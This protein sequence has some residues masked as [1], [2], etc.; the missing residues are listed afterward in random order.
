MIFSTIGEFTDE[1]VASSVERALI[2]ALGSQDPTRGYNV[3]SGGEGTLGLRWSDERKLEV[4]LQKRGSGNPM[5]GRPAPTRRRVRCLT[6]GGV[7][8]TLTE[9]AI[10]MNCSPGNVAAV[11]RGK[12]KHTKGYKFEYVV[13]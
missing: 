10:A 4:S 6:T 3:T 13:D 1:A 9:A 8:E 7:F 11:C 12:A 5:Y 2:S